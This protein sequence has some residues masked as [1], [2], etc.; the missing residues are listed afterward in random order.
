[1][2]APRYTAYT[3]PRGTRSLGAHTTSLGGTCAV[4]ICAAECM[5][6]ALRVTLMYTEDQGENT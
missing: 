5:M 4:R 2:K 1:M 3:S 6:R